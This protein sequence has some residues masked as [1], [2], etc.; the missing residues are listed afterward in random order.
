MGRT[1]RGKRRTT[2][3]SYAIAIEDLELVV[4]FSLASTY[5]SVF[6][7]VLQQVQGSCIGSPLSPTL[8]NIT[9]AI[10]EHHWLRTGEVLVRNHAYVNRYVDN[11]GIISPRWLLQH[12][13]MQTF[14]QLE[15]YIPPI[16]LEQCGNTVYLGQSIDL[17]NG[18]ISYVLP[19]ES[20]QFRSAKSAGSVNLNLMG[21]QSRLHIICR[22]SFPPQNAQNLARQLASLYIQRGHRR[23]TVLKLLQTV[24]KRYDK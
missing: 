4:Q 10:T 8:C 19:A 1:I 15:F 18:H 23:S 5:F 2:K 24:L 16:Q 17:E 11:R 3:K 14:I 6:E 7:L 9:V 21:F 12:P 22:D 20:W 13:E